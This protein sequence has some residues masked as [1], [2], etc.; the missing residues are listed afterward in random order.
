MSFQEE[1]Y[2]LCILYDTDKH[3]I[4]TKVG[5]NNINALNNLQMSQ[6]SLSYYYLYVS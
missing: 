3:L 2:H 6:S 1:K 4:S 5:L